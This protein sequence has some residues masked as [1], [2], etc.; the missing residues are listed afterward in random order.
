M[1]PLRVSDVMSRKVETL[2]EWEECGVDALLRRFRHFHHLP[3]VDHE[4]RVVGVV[5]PAD[6]LYTSMRSR[7]VRVREVMTTPA[8][9][10]DEHEPIEVAAKQM[11]DERIH[12]L[13][14]VGRSGELL[15]IVTGTDL[16]RALA[17]AH[18]APARP[19]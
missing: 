15:G 3:V 14:V 11:I 17:G 19:G 6:A 16:M 7:S 1:E 9:T 13:P 12:S 5:T 4:R 2:S 10:V 8:I 18:P